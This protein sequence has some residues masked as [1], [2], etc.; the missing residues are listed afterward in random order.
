MTLR[1]KIGRGLRGFWWLLD[2]T[3]RAILNLILLV[4]IVAVVWGLVRG[5]P[6]ALQPKTTLVLNF[7]GGIT[8]QRA[9]AS[10]SAA[11][12]QLQGDD[13][14]EQT[15]LRDVLAVLEAATTDANITQAVLLLDNFGGAGLATL[16]EV[17]A[18][19]ARFKAAGKPVLAWGSHFDQRQYFLAA[20]ASEVWLHPMGSVL[21]EGYGRPRTYYK[22]LLDKLG[23]QAHVIRAGKFKNF[24]ENYTANGPSPET[25]EA[26]T[27]LYGTLWAQWTASVEQA[28]KR[29]AGSVMAAIDSLPDS[30]V[31]LQGDAA[32]WAQDRGWVDALKTRDEMR[33]ALVER[34][35]P[36]DDKKTFRQV[37]F[38]DYLGLV[39]AKAPDRGVGPAVG[40]IVA[41]GGIG[42][43]RAGPGNIGG[44]STGELIRKA[45][46][47][48]QVKALVLRVNSPGGSAFGSELIRHELELTRKAGKPVVVSMGD[49]A[50]SGGYW[51][52]LAADEV[53]ADPATI[54]GSIG[55]IAM[56]PTA[57]GAMAKLGVNSAGTSTTW[58]AGGFN[59][60][61]PLAPRLEKL[62]QTGVDHTYF[63][64]TRLAA[65]ARKMTREQVDAV[66][67]GRVW[68][69]Q[70]AKARGL[71]DRM[72]SYGDALKAAA[73][74]GKLTE[75]YRVT[76][77]EAE[78]GRLQRWLERLGVDLAPG[79]LAALPA[80]LQGSLTALGLLP[81]AA[82]AMADDLAW[83]G[84][85]GTPG[86][87]GERRALG[88]DAFGGVTHCLCTAP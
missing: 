83:L 79:T 5:G 9:G 86:K 17:G 46:E 28:R 66:A 76:Y 81:P 3:R 45:R 4:L 16:R 59:P 77:L 13:D 60:L 78:P 14:N 70:D 12:R 1:S 44:L 64:F 22:D 68:T 11:L 26:D 74:R 42:D 84:A 18:A 32:R 75:G 20:Q 33:A 43:G 55:V 54:T 30:L 35:A 82:A 29:P 50:A 7:N 24:N 31:A 58:L 63:E 61:Q 10:R 48:D 19:L 6:A 67:Q 85:L 65:G 39:Q 80:G 36:S 47:D 52:S 69:G 34:G 88:T 41:A 27:L 56:L 8:E 37:A 71:V 25:T 2:G 57:E 23:V 72:G 21:V 51:I 73:T 49:V 53:I 15:R 62:I 40:V 38:N 87:P